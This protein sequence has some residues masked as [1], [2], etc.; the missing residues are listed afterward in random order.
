VDDG[1]VDANVKDV[2]AA[3][4]VSVEA[5]G[6]KRSGLAPVGYSATAGRK[7]KAR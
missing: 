7:G 4:P 1:L 6:F 2:P 5:G 3:L